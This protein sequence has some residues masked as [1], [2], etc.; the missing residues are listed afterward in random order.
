MRENKL[1]ILHIFLDDSFLDGVI[2]VF[3]RYERTHNIYLYYSKNKNCKFSH[4]KNV[5]KITVVYSKK[6]YYKYLSSKD[7]DVIYFQAIFP[8]QYHLFK[9]IDDKKIVI[10]WAWGSDL[11]NPSFTM[12]A[13]CYYPQYKPLTKGFIRKNPRNIIQKITIPL[14]S[15]FFKPRQK[16]VVSRVDYCKNVLPIE[17][18]LLKENVKYF[19]AKPLKYYM[20]LSGSLID[21]SSDGDI[22]LGNSSTA[23]NNHLDVLNLLSKKGVI[24]K[25]LMPLNY[26]KMNYRFYIEKYF[27]INL[28]INTLKTRLPFIE[29]QT[30]INKCS[31]AIFGHIRQQAVG[32]I[33]M[34]F[35]AGIKMFF[36]K[37]SMVFKQFKPLGFIIY[38][39]EDDLNLEELS[40]PLTKEQSLKNKKLFADMTSGNLETSR[41]QIDSVIDELISERNLRIKK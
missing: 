35:T 8:I 24:N 38:S 17:Y 2:N 25:I 34:C 14:L 9:Y 4:T 33:H 31:Y 21:H 16:K 3:E 36:Y 7:I 12:P 5:E 30:L 22:L 29:Y 37:D 27:P 19:R 11:Y 15:I 1:N 28:N 23:S 41:K 6:E 10:W 39:I 40:I 13:I 18:D 20:P 26:G 32:N